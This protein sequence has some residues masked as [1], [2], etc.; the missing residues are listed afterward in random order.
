MNIIK[1]ILIAI[2][3]Y[4]LVTLGFAVI[5]I[6]SSALWY[7]FLLGVVAIGGAVGY[8]LL[9]KDTEQPKLEDKTPITIAEM[10]DA[11]R[12]LEEYKRKY[13]SK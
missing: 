4:L 3:L 2:G 1:I 7:L 9:K 10:Q 8:K 5:G 11:D 6:V 13:L 12:A